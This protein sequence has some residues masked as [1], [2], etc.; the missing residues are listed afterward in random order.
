MESFIQ[1]VV[2]LICKVAISYQAEED[3]AGPSDYTTSKV[4]VCLFEYEVEG[5]ENFT[6][7]QVKFSLVLTML[8][9]LLVAN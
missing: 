6:N 2:G 3:F 9:S 7:R 1:V 8:T 5:R 4:L